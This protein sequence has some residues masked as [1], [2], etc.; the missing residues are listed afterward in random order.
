LQDNEWNISFSGE[1]PSAVDTGRCVLE[2][3]GSKEIVIAGKGKGLRSLN[4]D[5]REIPSRVLPLDIRDTKKWFVSL[6][7]PQYPYL[8][9]LNAQLRSAR[10]DRESRTLFLKIS[11]FKGHAVVAAIAG[12]ARVRNVSV[13]GRRITNFTIDGNPA[14]GQ[15]LTLHFA[16]A[17]STQNVVVIF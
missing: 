8:D 12:G 16:G 11:S 13:D 2:F 15:T 17:A 9:Q 1:L 4:A 5:G 3:G 7:L 14:G 6:G 10:F